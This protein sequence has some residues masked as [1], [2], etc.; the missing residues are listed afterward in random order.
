MKLYEKG[1]MY[2]HKWRVVN[3]FEGYNCVGRIVSYRDDKGTTPYTRLWK[4]VFDDD[5]EEYEEYNA[6]E[7]SVFMS[8]AHLE[9]C[10]GPAPPDNP[11]A[12][13][14]TVPAAALAGGD[15]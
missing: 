10:M 13:L 7:L 8:R 2:Y 1:A 11:S 4:C 9:G 3:T 6:K 12:Q 15:A 14:L 5:T